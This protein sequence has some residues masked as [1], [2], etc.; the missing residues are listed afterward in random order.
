MLMDEYQQLAERTANRSEV[1]S[2]FRRFANFGMGLAGEAGE[3]CDYLKKIVFHG[4]PLDKDKLKKELGDCLWYI[5]TL[6]TTAGLDLSDVAAAN[7][8]KLRARYPEGFDPAR[9]INRTP[10]EDD[11]EITT[12][13]DEARGKRRFVRPSGETYEVD[14][15]TEGPK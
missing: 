13:G 3:V 1:D 8:E 14:M 9:S 5:A 2:D 6:A 4:H 7:I 12:R 11:I 10:E 15:R